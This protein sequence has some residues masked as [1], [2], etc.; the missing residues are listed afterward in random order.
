M[1]TGN[2]IIS[3]SDR[4]FFLA[5]ILF[6][7]IA[8]IV[9]VLCGNGMAQEG[10]ANRTIENL[11]K[12]G[13]RRRQM[14]DEPSIHHSGLRPG[15]YEC[16]IG[17]NRKYLLYIP[18]SYDALRPTPLLL[19]FHGGGGHME[20]A[21][22]DYGWLGK[23]EK[24]SFIL[25]FPNGSSRL[26][27]QHL[28]TWNAGECCGYA[29]DRKIDDVRFVK[30]VIADIERKAN[31]DNG[32]I[33]AVG[34]SN[35]GMLAHRIACEMADTLRA[36]ASVAGTDNTNYCAPSRPISVMHIH[37]RDD[38]HVLFN[39]GAG[40]DAFRDKSKVTESTSVPETINRWIAR[41]NA[42]KTPRRI[43]DVPGAYADLYTS[44]QNKVQIELVVTDKGGHSWLGGKS[45][46]GEKP[47]KAIVANDIIWDFFMRQVR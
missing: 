27:R 40:K 34:M 18:L 24:E 29:C 47:S 41:N 44:K 10:S 5:R 19:F 32:K 28:A 31:V 12:S 25:A 9:V 6:V 8:S 37:A 23:S 16:R 15:E 30:Q 13:L 21:A 33:F 38:T 20:Q 22:K 42:E 45:V 39:G 26:P 2:T 35:G 4:G 43:I 14:G 3:S 1:N 46:R 7:L 36:V 11:E 17:S